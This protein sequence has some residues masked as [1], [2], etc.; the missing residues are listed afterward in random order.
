MMQSILVPLLLGYSNRVVALITNMQYICA[1][2]DLLGI[3][4]PIKSDQEEG[5]SP[6]Y[7]IISHQEEDKLW[8][9]E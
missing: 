8:P 5:I 9:Q 6:M 4:F 2:I 1:Y 3:R 7:Q